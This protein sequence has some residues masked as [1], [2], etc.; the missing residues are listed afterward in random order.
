LNQSEF[1]SLYK[2]DQRKIKYIRVVLTICSMD[3]LFINIY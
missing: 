2:T 3:K 1:L